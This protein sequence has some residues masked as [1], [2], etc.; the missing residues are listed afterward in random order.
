MVNLLNSQGNSGNEDEDE[1][2]KVGEFYAV[3]GPSVRDNRFGECY[4]TKSGDRFVVQEILEVLQKVASL[5]KD[6]LYELYVKEAEMDGAKEWLAAATKSHS[7]YMRSTL[8]KNQIS[9]LKEHADA[10]RNKVNYM[11]YI[12]DFLV[13]ICFH[14]SVFFEKV[15]LTIMQTIVDGLNVGLQD[16][17]ISL[18]TDESNKNTLVVSRG[19][20]WRMNLDRENFTSSVNVY[21]AS[22]LSCYCTDEKVLFMDVGTA[23]SPVHTA[24][25][26]NLLHSLKKGQPK[27]LKICATTIDGF[28]KGYELQDGQIFE[29]VSDTGEGVSSTFVY[30]EDSAKER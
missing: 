27:F 17:S 4:H 22:F 18:S 15:T 25:V 1:I 14:L 30:T 7:E 23:V 2:G 8:T 9:K 26:H 19:I 24:V 20:F 16:S 21:I 12:S 10:I 11:Y 3:E 13:V 28:I 6:E 5:S 29:Y